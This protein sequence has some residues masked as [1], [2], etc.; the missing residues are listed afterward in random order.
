MQPT[1]TSAARRKIVRGGERV[2]AGTV[3]RRP[4]RRRPAGAA[5]TT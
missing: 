5:T 3:H 1:T 2:G 4:A